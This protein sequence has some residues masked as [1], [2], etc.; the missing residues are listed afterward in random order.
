MYGRGANVAR[1]VLMLLNIP[2]EFVPSS[3]RGH[4]KA[5]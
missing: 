4:S 2:L 3:Y 1:R 5:S